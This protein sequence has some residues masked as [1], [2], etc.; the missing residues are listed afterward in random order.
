MFSVFV[1]VCVGGW[2]SYLKKQ[3]KNLLRFVTA[4]EV[5][6]D[7]GPLGKKCSL[8][9][10]LSHPT[11]HLVPIYSILIRC[12]PKSPHLKIYGISNASEYCSAWI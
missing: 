12:V 3:Q 8:S 7:M 9:F 5:D 1:R 10:N 2:G 11:I 6:S 4:L